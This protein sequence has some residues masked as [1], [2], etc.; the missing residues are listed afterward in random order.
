MRHLTAL[1][2]TAVILFFSSGVKSET[3]AFTVTGASTWKPFSFINEKGE[4]DGIMVDYW[5]L[6]AKENKVKIRFDLRPWGE[7][8]DYA[9][10][11][12]NVIHGGLGYTSDRANSLV[13]S[14]ELPLK[15]Y[16][17]YLFVQKDLPFDD[18]HSI[19]SAI[20]GTVKKSTKHAFLTAQISEQNTRIFSNFG[21]LNQAA[22]KGE[23]DIFIDDLS[24][25]LYDMRVTNNQGAFTPRRKLYSFPLHFAINKNSKARLA[26]LEEGISRINPKDIEAIYEKWLTSSDLQLSILHLNNTTKS[27]A[28]SLFVIISGLALLAYR[29]RFKH[30][31]AELKST[32]TAL[33]DSNEKL[34]FIVQNDP[35]TGAKTRH[36]FFTKLNELRFT[37]SPYVIAVL[38]IEHLKFIN[39]TYGQDIGDMALKHLTTQM[40]LLLCNRATIARLGGGKFAI[41]FELSEQSQAIKG[42]QKLKIARQLKSFYIDQQLI[43]IEFC[44]GVASYPNDSLDNEELVRMATEK[45]RSNKTK[46]PQ[47][48][49][50]KN[51]TEQ[52]AARHNKAYF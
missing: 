13:F 19:K 10:R 36:Q 47:K 18:L 42:L 25:A 28:I 35:V 11:T 52:S 49:P 17:V 23:V 40:R 38:G 14:N 21:A 9:I 22:Y 30:C 6:Y 48:T 27:A 29:K 34:Q 26:E 24:S 46:T 39:Q 4:P 41:L 5:Q 37:P 16:D 12:P 45:M 1:S 50:A 33:N 7:S 51:F 43:P 44:Y 3:Y 15:R 8:L 20:V 32:I 2:L 31:L